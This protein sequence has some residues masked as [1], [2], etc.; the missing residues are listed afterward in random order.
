MPTLKPKTE[1][2]VRSIARSHTEMAIRTLT[3]IAK[4]PKAQPS[5]RVAAAQALLDRG[6]GKPNQPVDFEDKTNYAVTDKPITQEDWEK[7]YGNGLKPNG[8][9]KAA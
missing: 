4:Q 3:A 5:A 9:G 2:D 1:K 8:N 6:W 7:Q